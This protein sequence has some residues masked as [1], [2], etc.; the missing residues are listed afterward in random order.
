MKPEVKLLLV[1][2]LV[3]VLYCS[4]PGFIFHSSL[5]LVIFFVC[6]IML[7]FVDFAESI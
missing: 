2:F 1:T 6:E 7:V 4:P 3:Q 5:F